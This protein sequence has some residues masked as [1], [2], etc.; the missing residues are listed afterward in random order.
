MCYCNGIRVFKNT[1]CSFA[2]FTDSHFHPLR[3][4]NVFA[5]VSTLRISRCKYETEDS[6]LKISNY[7]YH[8]LDIKLL[9]DTNFY[10][11]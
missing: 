9:K 6:T 4:E 8:T 3:E 1:F 10:F 5:K 7:R 11:Y 2:H